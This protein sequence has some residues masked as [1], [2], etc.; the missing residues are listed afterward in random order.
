MMKATAPIVPGF[1]WPVGVSRPIAAP[2]TRIWEVISSPSALALFHPFCAKN[3]VI[4]WPGPSSHDEVHYF[5]GLVLVRHFSDWYEDLGYDLEIGKVG[6]RTSAVSWRIKPVDD[7][8]GSIEITVFPHWLQTIP[9]IIR[10]I[11][12]LVRLRPQLR[13]YLRSVVEGLDWFITHDQSVKRNQFGSHQWFS[14]P[15]P[16]N[17]GEEA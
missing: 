2:S 3:P 5:N 8:R 4:D 9:A 6:G 16:A 11:P 13:A 17:R 14:P 12:H 15:A 1:R 7:H 10:W